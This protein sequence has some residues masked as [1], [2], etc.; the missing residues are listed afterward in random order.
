LTSQ[1]QIR[2]AGSPNQQGGGVFM[3]EVLWGKVGYN[4][5]RDRWY[6]NG[7]WQGQRLYYSTYQTILGHK[8]CKSQIEANQLQFLISGEMEQ[9]IFNPLRYKPSKPHHIKNYAIGWLESVKPDIEYATWKA[10]RAA[11]HYIID[12][13]GDSYIKDLGYAKIKEWLTGLELNLKTKKNYQGVLIR[14]MKDALRNGDI[15]QLPQFVEFRGGWTIPTKRKVWIDEPEQDKVLED[16]NPAD[17]FIFKFLFNTGV[18]VS[19]ARALR[20]K[21]IYRDRGYIMIRSTFGPV[22]GG[23]KLKS[24]KQ[25]H[26][27][28]IHFYAALESF[29][30]EIPVSI[31]SE[32]VF[33]NPKTG[34]P[35]TKNIN[36]DIWN[37]ACKK[38]LGRVVPLNNCGRHSFANQLVRDGVSMDVVSKLLGHSTVK[39]T[40]ENYADPNMN[41]MGKLVDNIRSGKQV[42]NK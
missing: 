6:V 42:A 35:Y 20:K 28:E 13:L 8:A 33:N 19:E 12:G 4:K 15:N 17:R 31:D 40:E 23:E 25:K 41:V 3:P 37:P 27:R 39:V 29:W 9:G 24:V 7:R 11:T 30:D 2:H 14:M 32:F 1:P 21:D 38:A 34:K 26:E 18:R 36:R 10:Y 16:I 5:A 22:P